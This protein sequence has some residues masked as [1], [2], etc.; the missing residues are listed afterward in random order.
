MAH[1]R[2]ARESLVAGGATPAEARQLVRESL[3]DL[4]L[5]KVTSPVRIPWN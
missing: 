2:I 1:S 5:Q 4:K 3:K